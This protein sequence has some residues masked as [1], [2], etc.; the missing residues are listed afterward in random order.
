MPT[1]E[2][3]LITAAVTRVREICEEYQ[4]ILI[5]DNT[6]NLVALAETQDRL[7][8]LEFELRRIR[9]TLNAILEF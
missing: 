4:Q 5:T 3:R 8:E 1:F 6:I 7:E 2:E 9:R